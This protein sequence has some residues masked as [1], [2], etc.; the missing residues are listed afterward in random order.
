MQPI[1]RSKIDVNDL[2][3]SKYLRGEDLKK[4]TTVT[5][6]NVKP[7]QL[8]RPGEGKVTGYIMYCEKAS[9]G[10]ILSRPLALAIAKALEE[11]DTEKWTGKQVVLFG[12]AM[13]VAGVPRVAIRARAITAA[14]GKAESNAG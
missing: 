7:E 12:Q 5:I 11:S 8:W 4:P 9:K 1:W 10:V 6:V 3:P 14:N 2:F 13:T